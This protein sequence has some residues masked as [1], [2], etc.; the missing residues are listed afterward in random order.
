VFLQR[1]SVFFLI[2]L[3][4]NFA[5]A[6]SKS[7]PSDKFKQLETELQS[8]N[9]QRTASGA[10]GN[11]YWQNRCDYV[12]DVELD[13][14]NQK[15]IG[16]E[17]LTYKNLSPDSLTYIWLQLDQNIFAKDSVAEKTETAPSL[18]NVPLRSIEDLAAREYDGRHNISNLKD[19]SGKPLKYTINDTMMRIDLPTPLAPNGTFVFSLDWNFNI[20]DQRRYDGRGG[21]EYFAQDGNYLY[22]IAHWFPRAVAYTDY[23]GWQHK[24]FL[25]SGEFTLEFGDYLVRITTPNDHVVAATGVLQNPAQAL[26]PEWIQRLKQAETAKEP[27]KIVTQEEATA[28]ESNKPTGKK[29]SIY[30]ADNVRDFAFAS[31]RKF[32]WDAQGHN[33]NANKTMAMSF[34]PKE[35]NP[36]WEKYST[37]AIIHTLNVYSRYSFD[38]PYPVAISVNGPVGG[39]EYPMI[40]FNGPRANPD[41]KTYSMGAKYGLIGVVIHEVGHN[42][43]PMIINSDER[44]WTWMDEG[45]NTF[46]QYLAEQE[47]EPNFPSR[48]GEPKNITDYMLS[49][50]QVP[51][52]TNSD[53]VL[54]FGNNGYAKPATALNILRETVLGRELFDFA[55]KTYA[56]RWK[57]KRPT[58][59]DFFRTMEDASGTDLDWFWRGWFYS[60]DHVDI[61]IENVRLFQ[62]DTKNP[63][64]EKEFARKQANSAPLS[65]SQI[66]NKN[67]QTRSA[68][69]PSLIDDYSNKGDVPITITDAEK[70]A[71]DGFLASLTEKEKAL[72]NG[73]YY[74]YVVDLKNIGGIVMPLIFKVEY[75][76]GTSEEIRIP[77]EIWRYNNFNVS[78][79]IVTKKEAKG[80]TLDPN[81]EIADADL[82]NNS[83]PRK[84]VSTRFQT[85]K[86]GAAPR[87]LAPAPTPTAGNTNLTGKWNIAVD[88]GGQTIKAV[89]NLVQTGNTINGT[90]TFSRGEVRISSGTMENGTFTLKTTV[91][92]VSILKGTRSGDSISGSFEAPEEAPGGITTFTGSK[93][94]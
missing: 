74:F 91:G 65:I 37:H 60:T 85:F 76:D 19:A 3:S 52:M 38:Y 33:V 15:I 63:Q 20:N 9:E 89:A 75:V 47:W 45:L 27:M 64:V 87:S 43:Y 8:P 14:V 66:R 10:P 2:L 26:K 13:D 49:E 62:L 21:W 93:A 1:L 5:F 57:F 80:V 72:V 41:G 83:L 29:T 4:V 50:N 42:Y 31:S 81:L 44:Q 86:T 92:F 61:A 53:S 70:S 58:P 94:L 71:Y 25:G 77:V 67:I 59:A 22:E 18:R 84:P 46:V 48:R 17:T 55:F 16:K 51:I 28:N 24:Q 35:G 79:L 73:G 30:K 88:A 78:K 82:S 54:Q 90:I 39:M 6:Q 34:Y 11:K 7:K 69:F 36:L 40:C 32:I 23:T 56:Q 12:I 68:E